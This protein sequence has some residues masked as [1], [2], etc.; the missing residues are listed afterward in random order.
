[1][2][3]SAEK[4]SLRHAAYT[5]LSVCA[6]AAVCCAV[7]LCTRKDGASLAPGGSASAESA[8]SY[9]TDSVMASSKHVDSSKSGTEYKMTSDEKELL[10]RFICAEADSE[11]YYAQVSCAAVILNR[12]KDGGFG[13][14]V[15]EAIYSDGFFRSVSEGT[16]DGQFSEK[17]LS[18]ARDAVNVA[19]RGIDP[20]GGALY[21]AKSGDT[22]CGVAIMY[23]CGRM[24]YG[25]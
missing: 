19:S 14:S 12:I 7:F 18:T 4:K 23:E 21:F 9:E 17:K 2:R 3:R 1:M 20:T 24:V 5:A 6:A 15:K 10:V 11:P 16:I 22:D 8:A 25:R 13:S